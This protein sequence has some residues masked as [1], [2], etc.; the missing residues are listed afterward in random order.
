M[1]CMPQAVTVIPVRVLLLSVGYGCLRQRKVPR[2]ALFTGMFVPAGVVVR[3]PM[4]SA[5]DPFVAFASRAPA[6]RRVGGKNGF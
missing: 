2:N 4:H 6:L 1:K 5:P 3:Y